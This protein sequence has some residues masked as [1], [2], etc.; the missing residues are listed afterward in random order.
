M[1]HLFGAVSSPG[2]LNFGL[3]RAADDVSS[4]KEAIDLLQNSRDLCARAGLK[5]HKVLSNKLEVLECLPESDRATSFK[6]FDIRTDT[7]SLERALGVVWCIQN[8]TFQFRI[9][10]NK[11]RCSFVLGKARVASLKQITPRLE[12][13][14]AVVLGKM[15]K[16]FK[17][18]SKLVDVKRIFL[19]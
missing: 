9:N 5:L 7:L 1:V 3:K 6:S 8:D 17:D 12:L 2:C 18:E 10:T 13:T 15:N 19:G 14:A 16:F 11:V 4:V